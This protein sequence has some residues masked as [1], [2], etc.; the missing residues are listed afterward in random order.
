MKRIL[1]LG[2]LIGFFLS[3]SSAEIPANAAGLRLGGGS[4]GGG[5]EVT[6]QMA[7][8]SSNRLE[9]DLGW[10]GAIGL[11]GV[12]Q[13]HWNIVDEW[14]WYAGP[15]AQVVL[16]DGGAGIAVGGQIGI[17]YNFNTMGVPLLLSIDTRP[18]IGLGGGF[19]AD[20]AVSVR[21]TF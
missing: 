4:Y 16:W 1:C 20:G 15:G 6:Y 21:Y 11:A 18:M 7:M 5:A 13:W 2:C 9:L 19:G 14:N 17:E 3:S 12:Y 10:G 8:G